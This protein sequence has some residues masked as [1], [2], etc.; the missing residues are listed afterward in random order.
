MPPG[1][2]NAVFIKDVN[3]LLFPDDPKAG[4]EQANKQGGFVFWNHPNW[5]SQRPDGI[6]RLEPLHKELIKKKLLHG[7]EVVNF[8]TFSEEAITIAL[9]NNLTILGT[10]DIHGLTSWDFD[11]AGGGHRPITFVLSKS[12]SIDDVK[13]ALFEGKTM[14]SVSYT[15]LTLPTKA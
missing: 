1:H 8:T 14:V 12:K 15:H 2:V 9:D 6:A 13:K 4:I 5:E 11:F 7:I 3:E 10:S